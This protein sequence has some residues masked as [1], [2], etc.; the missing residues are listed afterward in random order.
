MCHYTDP[1]DWYRAKRFSDLFREVLFN[2]SWL[3]G[4]LSAF[5]LENLLAD[6]QAI[7]IIKTNWHTH[8]WKVQSHKIF[9]MSTVV[10]NINSNVFS[11]LRTPLWRIRTD[12]C[13]VLK[14]CFATKIK[15]VKSNHVGFF[16]FKT[17]VSFILGYRRHMTAWRTPPRKGRSQTDGDNGHCVIL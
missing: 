3:H 4:K 8:I 5:P 11:Y 15:S 12:I 7:R 13:K 6:F 14:Y 17:Y 9:Y 10:D 2:Y 16:F 1:P